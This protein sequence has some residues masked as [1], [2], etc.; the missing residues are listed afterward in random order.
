MITKGDF[1]KYVDYMISQGLCAETIDKDQLFKE[2]EERRECSDFI[3]CASSEDARYDAEMDLMDEII[4]EYSC[5]E[6]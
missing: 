1:N 2:F 6:R 5:I 4:D 3:Q